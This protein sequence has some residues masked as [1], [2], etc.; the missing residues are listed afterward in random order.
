MAESLAPSL[1][2]LLALHVVLLEVALLVVVMVVKK[3]YMM[4]QRPAK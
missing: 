4:N 3:V 2:E 1:V